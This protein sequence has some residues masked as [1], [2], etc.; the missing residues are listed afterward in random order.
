MTT[1]TLTEE[2][3][4]LIKMCVTHRM[5]CFN[6]HQLYLKALLHKLESGEILLGVK[7]ETLPTR[8]IK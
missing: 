5:R 7:D 8:R 3:M 4:Q 1:I 6:T 2:E